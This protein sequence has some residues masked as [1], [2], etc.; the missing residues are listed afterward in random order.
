MPIRA[1]RLFL[2]LGEGCITIKRT[3]PY[4]SP[5]LSHSGTVIPKA[6]ILLPPPR[7]ERAVPKRPNSPYIYMVSLALPPLLPWH[8][9][10]GVLCPCG[11]GCL[12]FL[13]ARPTLFLPASVLVFYWC[14]SLFRISFIAYGIIPP[15]GRGRKIKK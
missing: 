14:F 15:G 4:P 6:H 3:T 13:V 8:F 1:G 11:S 12:G 9:P 5:A 7:K 2:L 10:A